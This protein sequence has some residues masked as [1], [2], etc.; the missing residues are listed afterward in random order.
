L[1]RLIQKFCKLHA[2]AQAFVLHEAVF[3]PG[4]SL[5]RWQHASEALLP[6]QQLKMAILADFAAT[7]AVDAGD[8][9]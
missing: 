8:D 1:Y 7:A 2:T 9:S 3:I 6:N 4:K 5:L